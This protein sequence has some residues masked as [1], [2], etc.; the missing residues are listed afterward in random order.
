MKMK[1][2]VTETGKAVTDEKILMDLAD[3][4]RGM[5]FEDIGL[6]SDGTPVV[7]DKCGNFGYLDHNIY[8]IAISA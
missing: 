3:M 2:V 1:V 7:F 6:Q 4:H 5:R 8:H